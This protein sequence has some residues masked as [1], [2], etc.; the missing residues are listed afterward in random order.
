[1]PSVSSLRKSVG[2]RKEKAIA[3][4]V[5]CHGCCP[6]QARLFNDL[7]SQPTVIDIVIYL[8]I[9]LLLNIKLQLKEP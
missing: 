2:F 8:D 4:A 9:T 1:M 5:V 6:S 7:A 3:E